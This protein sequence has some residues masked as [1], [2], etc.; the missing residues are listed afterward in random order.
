LRERLPFVL[1]LEVTVD[2]VE[3][4]AITEQRNRPNE[5]GTFHRVTE[6]SGRSWGER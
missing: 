3:G 5:A 2:G 6:L 1:M 4:V